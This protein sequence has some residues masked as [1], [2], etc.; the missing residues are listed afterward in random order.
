VVHAE[1][2]AAAALAAAYARRAAA[3]VEVGLAECERF[4]DAQ[5]GAPEHDDQRAQPLP[6]RPS[7]AARMTATISWT[8]GGSAA[9]PRPVLRGGR[10][11][12]KPGVVAGDR[13]RPGASSKT[14]GITPSLGS[15]APSVTASRLQPRAQA[16]TQPATG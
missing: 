10:P 14:F 7:P 8:F 12:W 16:I 11:A 15:R 1:L 13:R 2:A 4:V 5:T 9:D 6:W 3:R